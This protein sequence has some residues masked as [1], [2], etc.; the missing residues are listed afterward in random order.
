MPK[1]VLTIPANA[2]GN[3]VSVDLT[4]GSQTQNFHHEIELPLVMV[5]ALNKLPIPQVV[6][7]A[8]NRKVAQGFYEAIGIED[9]AETLRIVDKLDKVGGKAVTEMLAE[10]VGASAEQAR[11]ALALAIST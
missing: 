10:G 11:L 4:A 6:V 1:A 5:D 7:R 2:D 8:S 3:N 9:V